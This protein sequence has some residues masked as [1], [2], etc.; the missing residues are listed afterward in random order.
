[1]R[2]GLPVLAVHVRSRLRLL[3]ITGKGTL[4]AMDARAL[5]DSLTGERARFVRLARSRVASEAD[6]EDVVQRAL[7]RAV[8]R[9]WQ[10][11]DA[12]RARAWFYRI[13]RRAIVDHHRR[14]SAVV[15]DDVAVQELPA[16][17][18]RPRP[19]VCACAVRLLGELRPAYA[20]IVRRVD[21]EQEDPAGVARALGVS[22]TSLYVRLH[23]ARRALRERVEGHCGVSSIEPCL[24]CMCNAKHRCG[25]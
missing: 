21:F 15:S 9:A 3:G 6:A 20:E 18:E 24:E 4:I 5:I 7:T 22:M 23:R 12:S 10:L 11:A 19:P 2:P 13:L 17:D 25:S 8:E 14:K 1:V 16:D